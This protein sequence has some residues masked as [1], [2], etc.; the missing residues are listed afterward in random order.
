MHSTPEQPN[1]T[2]KRVLYLCQNHKCDQAITI[3]EKCNSNWNNAW[4]CRSH[5]RL[6]FKVRDARGTMVYMIDEI[7]KHGVDVTADTRWVVSRSSQT[8]HHG[9]V[10]YQGGLK[11]GS[12]ENA[13]DYLKKFFVI[14]A[15][16]WN[17]TET[18]EWIDAQKG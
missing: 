17:I 5:G 3:K 10:A 11:L 2:K 6:D 15:C 9:G 16:P 18:Q 1:S 13:V 8:C 4:I 12:V 7:L 14:K